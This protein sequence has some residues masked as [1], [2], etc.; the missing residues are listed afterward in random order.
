MKKKSP[1]QKE[2]IKCEKLAKEI[3]KIRDNYTCQKCGLQV[4]GSNCHASH[5]IPVSA[6]HRF[7][8]DTRNM[9]VLCYHHHINWWHKNPTE[10]GGWYIKTFPE[11]W[12]Y[13]KERKKETIVPLSLQYYQEVYKNLKKERELYGDRT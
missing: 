6:G 5:I 2:K 12:E 9:K 1:L 3:V 8:Y 10:A 13:L 4:E 7:A 11:N